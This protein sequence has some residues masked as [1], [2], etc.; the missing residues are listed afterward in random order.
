MASDL[1]GMA[2]LVSHQHTGLLFPPGDERALSRALRRIL[3]QPQLLARW[4]AAIPPVKTLDQEM[5]E[6]VS[7]YERVRRI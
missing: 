7:V 3:E 1:G 5:A 6:L 4:R 2:E